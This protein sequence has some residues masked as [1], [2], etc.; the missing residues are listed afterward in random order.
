MKTKKQITRK[1]NLDDFMSKDFAKVLDKETQSKI[2]G[3][4]I[5]AG[6]RQSYN[7]YDIRGG[8]TTYW[9][10]FSFY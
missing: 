6:R 4:M 2:T 8:D 3:G 1:L 10:R 5:W 7:V 9:L